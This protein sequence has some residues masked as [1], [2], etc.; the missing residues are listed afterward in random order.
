MS[1][2]CRNDLDVGIAPLL[3]PDRLNA[4]I[5]PIAGAS[6]SAPGP[7]GDHLLSQLLRLES[8]VAAGDTQQVQ[9]SASS[10]KSRSKISRIEALK[11]T[12]TSLSN[13]IEY[14]A[15]KL[16]GEGINYGVTTSMDVDTVLAP[17]TSQ[18]NLDDGSWAQVCANDNNE[19]SLRIQGILTSTGHSLYNGTAPQ[20]SGNL[21]SFRAQEEINRTCA[22]LTNHQTNSAVVEC[23]SPNSHTHDRRK[24][25]NGC[26]KPERTDKMAQSREHG[27]TVDKNRTDLLDSSAESIS[28]GPLLSEGSFSEDDAIPPHFSSCCVPPADHLAAGDFC[29]GQRKDYQRLSEFQKEASRL[30]AFSSPFAQHN[31]TKPAWEELNKGSPLSVIN[32]FTKNLQ[33]H[34]KGQ[35]T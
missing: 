34:I 7:G 12:A 10:N 1:L 27:L 15:Q 3:Q 14:E 4:D 21:H 5:G 22:N 30:S 26:E 20:G 6:S 17:R 31:G 29:A 13:R 33:G 19:M 35:F 8:A 18:T 2:L 11:A 32:I 16:A 28:E 23:P 24:L 25:V 9:R